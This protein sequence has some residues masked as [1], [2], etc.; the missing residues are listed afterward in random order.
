MF[1]SNLYIALL[2]GYIYLGSLGVLPGD[3]EDSSIDATENGDCHHDGH[4]NLSPPHRVLGKR[5]QG[6]GDT[7]IEQLHPIRNTILPLSVR[8]S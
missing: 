4:Q 8:I 3:G 1:L 6:E 5:L 7:L 2:V